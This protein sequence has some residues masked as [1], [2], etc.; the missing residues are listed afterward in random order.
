VPGITTG[1]T[2]ARFRTARVLIASSRDREDALQGQ[3]ATQQED[4]CHLHWSQYHGV[5]LVVLNQQSIELFLNQ[6]A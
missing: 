1:A 6:H 5:Q 3:G 2:A 4:D